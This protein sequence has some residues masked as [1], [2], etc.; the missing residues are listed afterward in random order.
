MPACLPANNLASLET[1]RIGRPSLPIIFFF[2]HL[3]SQPDS[4]NPSKRMLLLPL[5]PAPCE[6]A[7]MPKGKVMRDDKE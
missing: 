5:F 4:S 6:H 7:Y 3:T 2:V 1:A